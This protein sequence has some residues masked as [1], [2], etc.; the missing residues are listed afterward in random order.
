MT[1]YRFK[2]DEQLLAQTLDRLHQL[3]GARQFD[4]LFKVVVTLTLLVVVA[5]AG[6]RFWWQTLTVAAMI[7]C[8]PANAFRLWIARSQFAKSPYKGEDVVITAS[9]EGIDT[10]I[11]QCKSKVSWAGFSEA[12][13]FGDGVLLF[14]GPNV[15]GP[16]SLIW[17][18]T[19]ALE[20]GT[21][22]DVVGWL[23]SGD[24]RFETKG[25]GTDHATRS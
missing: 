9:A 3:R 24:V 11:G 13:L 7:F 6:G 18:P 23:R 20:E 4:I 22:A 17:L 5:L 15:Q 25:N 2:N 10:V 19:A 14:Q 12:S 21:Q 8:L 1:T 16:N